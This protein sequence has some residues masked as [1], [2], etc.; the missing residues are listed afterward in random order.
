MKPSVH[1]LALVLLVLGLLFGLSACLDPIS[2]LAPDGALRME[3]HF[4]LT[5]ITSAVLMI[6]NLSRTVDVTNV[7]I[8]Y[9]ED[10]WKDH[11]PGVTDP[12]PWWSFTGR[13]RALERRAQYLPPTDITYQVTI[14][15]RVRD[16]S[17]GTGTVS[18][19][20]VLPREIYNIWIY[21]H[22][23]GSVIISPHEPV[24]PDPNDTGTPLDD[25]FEGE[26]STPPDIPARN[27]GRLSTFIVANTSSSQNIDSIYFVNLT[28]SS[29]N[30]AMGPITMNDNLAIALGHGQWMARVNY[31]VNG[32]QMSSVSTITVVN[33]NDPQASRDHYLYFYKNT[34]GGFETRPGSSWPPPNRDPEDSRHGDT[35]AVHVRMLNSAVPNTYIYAV[36]ASRD[37]NPVPPVGATVPVS[38]IP[39]DDFILSGV[40]GGG[41]ISWTRDAK[42]A[43]FRSTADAAGG[44]FMI[45]NFA[46]YTLDVYVRDMRHDNG[47][48]FVI[49][50]YFGRNFI[51]GDTIDLIITDA[52]IKWAIENGQVITPPECDCGCEGSC[53]CTI[54]GE[55]TCSNCGGGTCPG[56]CSCGSGGTCTCTG[57]CTCPG[58]GTCDCSNG[59]TCT[60]TGSCTCPGSTTCN[61]SNGGTCT[62]TTCNCSGGPGGVFVPV[63]SVRIIARRSG[64]GS[65]GTW[66]VSQSNQVQ[67][68]TRTANTTATDVQYQDFL[69]EILPHNA[70]NK[71][72]V[73]SQS[74]LPVE[75]PDIV[76]IDWLHGGAI[77]G[78]PGAAA[79]IA[80]LPVG[81]HGRG[82][83]VGSH[84]GVL[85]VSVSNRYRTT[86]SGGV[87]MTNPNLVH[88][89]A[90]INYGRSLSGTTPVGFLPNITLD[91]IILF[92]GHY[93]VANQFLGIVTAVRGVPFRNPQFGFT[94][95]Y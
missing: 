77:T 75:I 81:A 94:L 13:P 34:S 70:T 57:T 42:R 73:W 33:S 61:C 4:T 17:N 46:P 3:G 64:L 68:V 63:E 28:N 21:R 6:N 1:R 72:L 79:Y 41:G 95:T 67:T 20:A 12:I 85:R 59:G 9:I 88:L 90:W 84:Y 87:S 66:Q 23:D 69:I 36:A 29:R 32:N 51:L 30:Y 10:I 52:D 49:V 2:L 50:R 71:N 92:S 31:T 37:Y 65:T 35:T 86:L 83:V 18:V 91:E 39:S 5:D 60:C 27:A 55:C 40:I 78:S 11:N 53:G 76:Q 19:N 16:G 26:G 43:I 74:R 47:R 22:R 62:C 8:T 48:G 89:A 54:T 93:S 45:E 25:P 56:S 58:P 7:H 15:Y 24:D 38:F 14:D 44:A 82:N 80:S